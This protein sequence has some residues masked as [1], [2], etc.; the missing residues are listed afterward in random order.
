MSYDK[1]FMSMNK[2]K[3]TYPL[4]NIEE[5]NL[6]SEMAFRHRLTERKPKPSKAA[7]EKLVSEW[8]SSGSNSKQIDASGI[9]VLRKL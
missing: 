2:K 9:L 4:L 7:T 6:L 1:V 3:K 5:L 8:F